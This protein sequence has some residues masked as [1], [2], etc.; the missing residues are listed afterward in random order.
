MDLRVSDGPVLLRVEV[1]WL[2]CS[3]WLTWSSTNKVTRQDYIFNPVRGTCDKMQGI[4]YQH[5]T[6]E[7][8]VWLEI[9]FD[10]GRK[11]NLIS[12][13]HP[14]TSTLSSYL[15]PSSGTIPDTCLHLPIP[16]PPLSA[17]LGLMVLVP[18]ILSRDRDRLLVHTFAKR[19][20][21]SY[22]HIWAPKS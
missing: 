11:K 13:S 1:T 10:L 9:R 21:Y 15:A 7:S 18:S 20:R 19:E 5:L 3:P 2:I 14:S 8:M 12:L 17:G 6:I 4:S 16:S 22:V